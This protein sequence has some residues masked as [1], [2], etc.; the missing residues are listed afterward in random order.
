MNASI[1]T[2][3]FNPAIDKSSSVEALL[4]D[5]KMRCSPPHFEP[6]GGGVNVARA[7]IKLG[8]EAL[9]VYPAGG[10]SGHFFNALMEKEGVPVIPVSIA[11]HTREN[12]VI[13][14]R[15]ANKQYRFGMPGP[16]LVKEE[17]MRLLQVIEE[18][19][20]VEFLVASGSLAPGVP[21]D[22]F[23]RLAEIAR[24]KKAKFIVDTSGDALRYAVEQGVYLLKPNL[25][26]LAALVKKEWLDDLQAA[27]AARQL[28]DSGGCEVVVVS[29]GE[30]GAMLVTREETYSIKP[31][32][33]ERKSTVGAGDSMV[34]GIV[35]SLSQGR[36]LVQAVQ[37]GVACGT[38]ATMN[39]GTELCRKKDADRLY[40][41]IT[42]NN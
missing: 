10:F 29:L 14:D 15:G 16:E 7:I 26:E 28:I 35:Y 5:K 17:W 30:A 33:V 34:A 9:A 40:L 6:G 38:A 24:K 32:P 25:G 4:P 13:L 36:E 31:P 27:E 21:F 1:L 39:P 42:G 12:L 2:L 23:G 41:E 20:G 11:Q 19:G 37:Y 8:G 3:S 18:T 22:I